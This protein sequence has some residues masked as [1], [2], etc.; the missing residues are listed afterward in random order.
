MD[1]YSS[2]KKARHGRTPKKAPKGGKN[3]F[4]RIK[5]WFLGMS[6][7]KRTVVVVLTSIILVLVIALSIIVGVVLDMLKDYNHNDD[8]D[9][10]EEIQQIVPISEGIV[11]IALFGIDSRSVSGKAS[12]KGLS[13]SI[14]ILSLNTDTGKINIISVMRDSLV[15]IPGKAVNKINAAY[16]MGGAT[17]AIKTLNHNF[18]LD[19]KE[20]ATVNFYGM[21]EIID[22]VG[23]IEIDV[24]KQEINGYRRLNDLITEL[25]GYMGVKAELVKG[26]GL[27]T[28][29]GIQAVSWARIRAASTA[30]GEAN[31]YGRTDRQRYVME[32]LLN[33]ALATSISEYPKLIKALLPYMETSLSYDEIFKLAG[34]LAKDVTF[35]QTRIPQHSYTLTPPRINRVGSSVY[36]NLDFAEDIIHALIYDGVS[37]DDYIK[38]NG[39]VKN[40]WY[41]GPTDS[42]KPSSSTDSDSDESDIVDSS[43]GS[44]DDESS[45]DTSGGDE[46]SG[47]STSSEGSDDEENSEDA[48]GSESQGSTSGESTSQSSTSQG[49]TSTPASNSSN[50]SG[51]DELL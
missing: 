24:Q 48:S 25:A 21:A 28:L 17:L 44:S 34:I 4:T 14:M 20:Y 8:V 38:S 27:Q 37:Q 46:S 2:K 11:N 42:A 33:K 32:Q 19:I 9:Q 12:F 26:P 5:E 40:G 47:D 51:S 49:G 30:T 31:D 45:E 29:N 43:D 13:D 50:N 3:I 15:E 18:G 23:G 1:I 16:S 22:A 36:Y 35:E 10:D 7:G 6:T 41:K 39:V